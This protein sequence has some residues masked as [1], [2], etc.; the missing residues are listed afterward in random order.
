[1]T[2]RL[3]AIWAQ[4]HPI[5]EEEYTCGYC[6]RDVAPNQ[7]YQT[8]VSNNFVAICPG[9][10]RPSFL[11]SGKATPSV[12]F[13][14]VV[15]N[16]PAD[17]N[18]IYNALGLRTLLAHIA[19][20]RSAKHGLKFH[21]Y[22][23]YLVDKHYVPTGREGWVDTLRERGNEA[24]HDLDIMNESEAKQLISFAEMILKV[25]YEFPARVVEPVAGSGGTP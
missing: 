25:M 14:A 19:V 5:R 1:M 22:M 21:E 7:G 17:A 8:N 13:G 6:M 20:E 12:A 23:Q 2:Q 9:C 3:Q 10:N 24:A 4:P 18:A 11:S 15:Q 16:V